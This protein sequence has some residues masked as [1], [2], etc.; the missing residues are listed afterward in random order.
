MKDLRENLDC[1][2][3]RHW[4]TIYS[5]NRPQTID[6]Y[7]EERSTRGIIARLSFASQER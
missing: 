5:H 1:Q 6:P 2:I 7:F 4:D 3:T